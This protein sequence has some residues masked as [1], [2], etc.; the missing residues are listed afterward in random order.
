[1]KRLLLNRG[2]TLTGEGIGVIPATVPGCV[3]TDL[4]SNG[5]IGDFFWRDNNK[6]F[7]WIESRDWTY[8][9]EFDAPCGEDVR[10]VFEG[11]DTYAT[12]TLNGTLLG[13]TDNM[14]VPH[15]F[16]VSTLLKEQENVLEV[17][18][19]SPTKKVEHLPPLKGA[20]T[21]ERLYSR[22]LQC[23]YGWDWVDRFVT[24]GIYR[25]V[26]LAYANGIDV[27]DVYIYT[28][29]IDRFS[30]Q[31]C[32]EFSFSHY[33]KGEI[34]RASVF[35]PDGKEVAF[36]EFFAD[37]PTF[38]R[39]FD[40]ADARLWYPNGYG[41]Q[42]LYRLIITVGENR[43]EQ[44][45]GIRTLKVMQL[46]DAEGSEYWLR[47]TDTQ[48]HGVATKYS[49]NTHFSGFLVVV[50]GI[51]ILC[52]GAN[53]VPCEPFPSAET[54]EKIDLLVKR[55]QD[56]GMNFLRV[57]GGGLFEQQA[58]YDAC[59]RRGILVA[60]DFLMACG[61]YPEK[62]A[63]FIEHLK[64][65]S[66]F[67]VKYLRNHPSLAWWHGD[68]ENAVKG[69]DVQEDY[70]GRDSAL[71]GL[72]EQIYRFDHTRV[73]LP[74]SPYGGNTYA[75]VTSGTTHNTNYFMQIFDH[76]GNGDCS[77]YKEYL[78][79]FTARFVSEE[80]TF[81]AVS[82]PSMLKMM[83]EDDLLRDPDEEIFL[84]HTKTN[85]CLKHHLF[86]DV[87]NF[88][89]KLLGE[90]A[91]GE[92]RFFKYKYIQYEWVR[93]LLENL[94]RNI[95]YCNGLLF[96]MHNDCWPAAGGWSFVDYYGLPKPAYYAFKRCTAPLTASF[97][98]GNLL[99]SNRSDEPID[100]EATLHF[101]SL[102]DHSPAKETVRWKG[103]APAYGVAVLDCPV[104]E[105]LLAV[106]DL[107]FEGE[108]V[109]TFFKHGALEIKPLDGAVR[110]LARTDE[111][112]VLIA[113]SYVHA[114]EL[115]GQFVFDDNYFS[116]LPGEQKT[117][118]F[119]PF[120]NHSG[121]GFTVT[122]YTLA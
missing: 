30:A 63:W 91:D 25:P 29:S 7:Q 99:V 23:T 9:T 21:T 38:V 19:A 117:V 75:S 28:E 87:R 55:A 51:R 64:K 97:A 116:M 70:V 43:M 111:S 45:F 73:F 59:D 20:F 72:A 109:R 27:E 13:E 57:W 67:A 39:R 110:V 80:P 88:A 58:F 90:F 112:I 17:C 121:N 79:L 61:N 53:W 42:P 104:S 119:T 96:W 100:F 35:D 33:E 98:D 6:N 8:R 34:A 95:G 77:D 10:L 52:M 120:E 83:T 41:E 16:D 36:C 93:V 122:T 85:P 11:L 89:R 105:T 113:D 115:E 86:D 3:H 101:F 69:S 107:V 66:M 76:V 71:K 14:F 114:V 49:K 102:S 37:Q 1:M 31:I 92:D 32:A 74:S 18:F 84:Y 4:Q 5:V 22:R 54:P 24:A 68:N 40:V 44:I 103:S 2:W 46:P 94:R 65:E 48:M 60:Q 15:S 62:E 78:A 108:A 56:M 47:A 118:S 82:R 12:V 50:N 106:C 26:Y 81:G